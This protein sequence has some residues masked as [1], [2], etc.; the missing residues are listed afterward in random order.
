MLHKFDEFVNFCFEHGGYLRNHLEFGKMA[1]ELRSEIESLDRAAEL[2]LERK[3][4]TC[5]S[6]LGGK[7]E[8][9]MGGVP[10]DKCST[11]NGTGH[12]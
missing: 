4:D 11:C 12:V 1:R 10:I 5:P 7:Y 9:G 8:I 6:C 2:P 3:A